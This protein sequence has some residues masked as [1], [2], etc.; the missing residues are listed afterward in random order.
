MRCWKNVSLSSF[1]RIW[2]PRALYF[3]TGYMAN[4]AVLSAL[5]GRDT[6]V[7]SESLNHASLIDGVRLSRSAVK[8]FPHRDTATLAAMLAASTATKKVVV[9][10]SVFS[11]DGDV[12]PLPELLALCE[13]HEAW[14]IVDDA[15]GFGVMGQHGRGALEHFNLHSP[16]LIYMGTLGKAAGVAGAFVAAHA[17]VIEW[18][19]QRARP[20]IYT[21]AAPP[22]LA[23]ALLTSLDIIG[24]AE[25]ASH[26]AHLAELIGRFKAKLRLN[27]WR[28]I[29]SDTAIQPVVIGSNDE[30]LRAS[31]ELGDHG[32]W[33]PAIRPPTVPIGT[34]RLRVTLSAAHSFD[35]VDRL[36]DKLNRLER[37]LDMA[38]A[39]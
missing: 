28:L 10:D 5:A 27:R 14:L 25:G 7:F 16:Y 23:H 18:L 6:Q 12:A 8:V 39:S 3:S 31:A 30:T 24:G 36:T 26:R 13:R 37:N 33:V 35:D 9:T 22:A 15:H 11:M 21:T 34:A 2:S 38:C 19:I 17:T 32:L 20:Y 29:A 1:R 4:L